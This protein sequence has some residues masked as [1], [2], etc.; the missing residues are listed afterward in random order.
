LNEAIG[1]RGPD[2]GETFAVEFHPIEQPIVR[3]G[4]LP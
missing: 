2:L 4:E 1:R 3:T